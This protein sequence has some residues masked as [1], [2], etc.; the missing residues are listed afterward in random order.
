MVMLVD[1]T[2]PLGAW[3]VWFPKPSGRT[4]YLQAANMIPGQVRGYK[5]GPRD[6]DD[7]NRV[8]LQLRNQ[9]CVWVPQRQ[10]VLTR[11]V[12][13]GEIREGEWQGAASIPEN[14]RA[15]LNQ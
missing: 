12:V 15:A 3:A 4:Y 5:A 2:T 11:P 7:Q 1:S 10:C 14:G 6:A 9:D 13:G 8:A